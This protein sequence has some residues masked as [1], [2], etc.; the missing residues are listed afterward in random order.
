MEND[1]EQLL[2]IIEHLV[3]SEWI[4]FS[5]TCKSCLNTLE[6]NDKHCKHCGAKQEHDR[7]ILIEDLDEEVHSDVLNLLSL[8]HKAIDI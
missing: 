3:L 6:Y 7:N 2:N 8:I 4:G 1:Q 5:V